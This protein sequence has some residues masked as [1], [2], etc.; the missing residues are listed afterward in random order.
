MPDRP[1]APAAPPPPR[2]KITR[3]AVTYTVNT[4]QGPRHTFHGLIGMQRY[5]RPERLRELEDDLTVICE[6]LLANRPQPAT[7]LPDRVARIP[8]GA[9]QTRPECTAQTQ[10][11]GWRDL[12]AAVAD[13]LDCPPP[14]G[15][16]DEDAFLRLRSDRARLALAALRSVLADAES[17]P[18]QMS[19]AAERLRDGAA[20]CPADGYAVSSLSS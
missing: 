8:F 6:D 18:D 11:G 3:I 16:A 15:Q 13:A 9:A 1:S 2:G 14:A 20:A 17:G 19:A 5:V 4:E 10:A 7:G 12:L